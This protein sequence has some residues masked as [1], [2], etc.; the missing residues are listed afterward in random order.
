MKIGQSYYCETAKKYW[1]G[2]L[3]ELTLTHAVL[4][5]AAWV[6]R[7]GQFGPVMISGEL[8]KVEPI[9]SG[10]LIYVWLPGTVII[11]WPHPLPRVKIG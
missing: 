11:E 4:D 2:R 3:V 6:V 8:M 5:D 9:P 7:T 1:T 10:M